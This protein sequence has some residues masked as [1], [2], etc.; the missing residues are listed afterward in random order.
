VANCP[1]SRSKKAA[2]LK[3]GFVTESEFNRVVDPVNPMIQYDNII[4]TMHKAAFGILFPRLISN[5]IA[6]QRIAIIQHISG[7]G[8]ESVSQYK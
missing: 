5:W 4:A 3:L 8:P 1:W 6:S 2:A 7:I